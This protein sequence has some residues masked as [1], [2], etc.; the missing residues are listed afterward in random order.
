MA[1]APNLVVAGHPGV[2]RKLRET[3]R[4]AAVFEIGSSTEL[5]AL[6]RSGRSGP[7]TAFMF[8]PGFVEDLPGASVPVLANGLAASGYSV[9][10]HGFFAERGDIFDERV[11]VATGQL[12]L[13]DLLATFGLTEP[14]RGQEQ[15]P[16]PEAG[17]VPAADAPKAASPLRPILAADP[18]SS[19][20]RQPHPV[21]PPTPRP[22]LAPGTQ[23][24][25]RPGP[26]PYP[27]A[28]PEPVPRPVH[29]QPVPQQQPPP[30]PSPDPVSD[31]SVVWN[32]PATV[33]PRPA[34][35]RPYGA[36]TAPAVAAVA[37]PP[38]SAAG[39]RLEGGPVPPPAR[40]GQ[41]IAVASAKG[42]VGKTSA[43]VNLAVYAARL[44]QAAGRP[45]SVAVADTN[46]QQA[47]VARFLNLTSPTILDLFKMPG[48]LS[49]ETVRGHLAHVPEVDLFALLGPP[50]AMSADPTLI[51]SAL[52]RGILPVLR[53][54]FDYVFIDTPVA[55]LYHMTLTDLVLPE[56][57][58]ILVPVEPNRVTL[59]A[60]RSWLQAIT[61]PQHARGGGVP[62]ERLS[63]VLNRARG[64]VDC[65]P[66]EVMDLMPGWRFVGMIPEDQE[67]MQA[68]NTHRL[69]AL[70]ADPDLEATFRSILQAVSGDPVFEAP[71]AP[72]KANGWRGLLGL[73]RK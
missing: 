30:R 8:A 9:I 21:P 51:N 12:M 27:V 31:A 32:S 64:D 1:T 7:P 47:D 23:A 60:A 58:A 43:T 19:T 50:D 2:A 59:E 3:G 72:P 71:P 35:V 67:W 18:R 70:H 24:V 68:V 61:M 42:G 11:T 55:E 48:P 40:R 49:A 41:V 73:P 28:Q 65:G 46:F 39:A 13:S 54:A 63:L 34:A 14:E 44:L 29:H 69:T 20:A 53:Q 33:S 22:V 17:T 5:R 56:A 66:E 36:S 6:S 45:G 10:V 4:F 26:Q 62:P 37:P 57:D 52:Y 38:A 16:G 15:R 25:P